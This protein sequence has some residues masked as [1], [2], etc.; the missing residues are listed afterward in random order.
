[1]FRPE[2]RVR[3]RK[4]YVVS[5]QHFTITIA[6]GSTTNTAT[7]NPVDTSRSF[8][9]YG[10]CSAG[11]GNISRSVG[12]LVLTNG[13]T[14]TASRAD[15]TAVALVLHGCVVQ[16]APA[17]V[18]SVQV[19]T[20]TFAS[21]TTATATINAVDA[22]RSV[23]FFNGWSASTNSFT[24]GFSY[25]ALTNA[26]TVTGTCSAAST[27]S[28]AFT[29]VEFQREAV[30]SVQS[31]LFSGSSGTPTTETAALAPAVNPGAT[32]VSYGGLVTA[33]AQNMQ[34]IQVTDGVTLSFTRQGNGASLHGGSHQ[35]MQFAAGV[36]RRVQRGTINIAS[37]NKTAAGTIESVDLNR[38]W[39]MHLG[40]DCNGTDAITA[41]MTDTYL[42]DQQTVQV[43]CFANGTGN[44]HA[45]EVV[46]FN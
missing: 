5:V 8:I 35:V 4:N 30:V 16:A 38:S 43:D 1:M 10:G 22:T 3:R 37:G 32:V 45:Y 36:V 26:T 42:A 18:K 25:L 41:A 9:V 29:I 11:G 31:A 15:G 24:A 13:T 23:V 44:N 34:M 46:S 17:L 6:S 28:A 33:S 40:N 7:I 14:V 39:C 2:Q 27:S 12:T 21:G 20:V 19:G